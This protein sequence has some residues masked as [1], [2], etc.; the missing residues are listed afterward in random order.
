MGSKPRRGIWS[1]AAELAAQTPASRNRAVDF[2]RALSILAV[3]SGHWL[4]AAPYAGDGG[5]A[6]VNMLER[7]PWTQWLTWG[8][9]VMPVFFFVG[10]YANGV[11]WEAALR[12][13][14]SYGQWLTGRLSRLVGPVLPLVATWAVLGGV[15]TL[16]DVPPGMVRVGSQVAL[17]PIWFLS[18]YVVVVLLVPLTYAV[19]Q[20]LG[21][22]S[23]WLLAALAA[24]DDLIFFHSGLQLLGVLNYFFVW[25]AVHQLGYAWYQGRYAGP[26]RTCAFAVLGLAMLMTAVTLGPYPVSMVSVPGEAVSNSLPPKLTMLALGLVQ[27]GLLLTLERPLRRWLERG[28]P[29]TATI[30]LNGMIMTIYLWHITASALVMGAAILLGNVGLGVAPGSAVW[31]WT[32]PLWLAAY[33]GV[34]LALVPVVARFETGSVD[35][36]AVPAWRRITGALICCLGLALLALGGVGGEG[37]FGLRLSVLPLPFVGAFVAGLWPVRFYRSDRRAGS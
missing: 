7:Q 1:R 35:A 13:N 37:W 32:R 10:G 28:V 14:K 26:V 2:L 24:V 30:L 29:W 25:L 9:Q 21:F 16:L 31:W 18:V 8:F 19:W 11:S 34:L 27:S 6:L 33:L 22:A 12:D 15:A 17:V 20:R 36:S 3:I 23:F 4:L 5:L